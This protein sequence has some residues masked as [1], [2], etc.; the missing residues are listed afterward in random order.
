MLQNFPGLTKRDTAAEYTIS[1]DLEQIGVIPK[2]KSAEVYQFPL[3]FSWRYISSHHEVYQIGIPWTGCSDLQESIISQ[4]IVDR[5]VRSLDLHLGE[6]IS[7]TFIYSFVISDF[8]IEFLKEQNPTDESW[9]GIFLGKQV[10]QCSMICVYYHL[11][12][13]QVRS[14]LIHGKRTR[15]KVPSP[16]WDY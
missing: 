11:S 14:K 6:M 7:H 12:T 9:L 13:N 8:K 16:L 2:V 15:P 4:I 1:T 3:V 5:K 10:F